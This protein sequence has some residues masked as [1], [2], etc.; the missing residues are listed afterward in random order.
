MII[1]NLIMSIFCTIDKTM[2]TENLQKIQK[3][4]KRFFFAI[5]YEC[6][7]YKTYLTEE[8]IYRYYYTK[9]SYIAFIFYLFLTSHVNSHALWLQWTIWYSDWR[10]ISNWKRK[11]K[12]RRELSYQ[13]D[14]FS[15][16][17]ITSEEK[18][19]NKTKTERKNSKITEKK[20]ENRNI[21]EMNNIQFPS[22]QLQPKLKG[23]K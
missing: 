6:S 15:S 4:R 19:K 16:T 11:R 21:N 20:K 7:S 18:I 17:Q 13:N 10:R 5:F 22:N 9:L 23:L 8:L 14:N 1:Q 12:K 2:V 3:T